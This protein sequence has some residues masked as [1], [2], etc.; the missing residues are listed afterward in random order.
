MT[1]DQRTQQR[2]RFKVA[3][4][5]AR[6][7]N[8]MAEQAGFEL[9]MPIIATLVGQFEQ[10]IREAGAD[11]LARVAALEAAIVYVSAELRHM[12]LTHQ[13]GPHTVRKV[14]ALIRHCEAKATPGGAQ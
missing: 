8:A 7:F 3:N 9:P 4:G 6:D 5:Y 14:D 13:L 11:A 10:A 2:A 12:R 1:A